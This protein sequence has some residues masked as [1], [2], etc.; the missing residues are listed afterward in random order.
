M[1]IKH[2]LFFALFLAVCYFPLFLHLDSL[3]LRLWDEA[4][5]GVNALEMAENGRWLVPHFDGRPDMYGTKPPLLIWCQV[6]FMKLFGYG[7]LAVR[8]PSALA[9][10]ATVLL[11]VWFSR[12]KLQLPL[13][14]IFGG[15]TLLTTRLYI[16]SHGA[17]S[18][19]YDALLTLF[20]TAYALFFFLYLEEERPRYLYLS[21]LFVV[22]AGL[23]KGVAGLFFLPPLLVYVLIR[24]K[25]KLVFLSPRFYALLGACLII[26][27]GYY[28]L[29]EI[30]NPGYLEAVRQNELGGRFLNQLEGHGHGPDFYFRILFEPDRL[31]PWIFFWPLGFLVCF[32]DQRLRRFAS[33]ALLCVLGILLIL[34]TSRTKIEWYILPALPLGSLIVGVGVEKL[35]RGL[36]DLSVVRHKSI[37][38]LFFGFFTSALFAAPYIHIIKKIYV[39]NHSTWDKDQISYRDFMNRIKDYKEYTILHPSYNG[40]VVFYKTKWNLEGYMIRQQLLR[41]PRPEVQ[42]FPDGPPV[43]RVGDLVA[44]CEWEAQDYLEKRYRTETLQSWESCRLHKVLEIIYPK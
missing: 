36:A 43:F 42:Q 15:L 37:R 11:L 21:G 25:A 22:L 34:S 12:R 17:V 7:E 41:P 31:Y 18:G 23:T 24:K 40:H 14:G 5:R 35:F 19:D 29:R 30:Q 33:L 1:K 26:F 2:I 10:L 20:E 4:R 39:F 9:G 44:V 32:R 13:A 28:F 6:V 8:L 27:L 38:Y 3:S 16:N